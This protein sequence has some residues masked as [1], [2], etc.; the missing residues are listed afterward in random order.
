MRKR[1][2]DYIVMNKIDFNNE[3]NHINF[4]DEFDTHQKIKIIPNTKEDEYVK[5]IYDSH[6]KIILPKNEIIK[7]SYD[8][9]Y[10]VK[11]LHIQSNN[12]DKRELDL[13][14]LG[15][16]DNEPIE[17]KKIENAS[18]FG[19]PT[20]GDLQL[21]N[22]Q[23]EQGVSNP[24]NN[25]IRQAQTGESLDDIKD[26]DNF[27]DTQVQKIINELE[28]KYDKNIKDIDLYTDPDD[29]NDQKEY[30]KRTILKQKLNKR[31]QI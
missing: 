12:K 5:E 28:K 23:T 8:L 1:Y 20:A 22:M 9:P 18:L 17:Y 24:L 4:E 21:S 19:N 27:I 26:A 3:S 25:K 11:P 7:D 6:M 13:L 30:L 31:K 16:E 2:A 29:E 14:L 15:F 10:N